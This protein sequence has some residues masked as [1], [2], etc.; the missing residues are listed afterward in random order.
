[1][2]FNLDEIYIKKAEEHLG[3]LLPEAYKKEMMQNNGGTIILEDEEWELF[4]I[5]DSSDKKRIARTCN[6]IVYETNQAKKWS[7][8]PKNA[9]AI[10]SNGSGDLLTLKQDNGKYLDKIYIWNHET[11][12]LNIVA[13]SFEELEIE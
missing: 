8:F 9:L 2:A 5:A 11:G 6:H 4:P 10:A 13:N 1:M 7:N 3:A 12:K